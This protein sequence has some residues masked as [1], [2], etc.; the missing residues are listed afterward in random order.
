MKQ[1][2]FRMIYDFNNHENF[3]RTYDKLINSIYIRHLTKRL[4]IYIEHCSKC[5]LHQIKR[6]F[7]YDNLQS[8]DTS[9]IFFHT[10]TINFILILFIIDDMNCAFTITCKCNKKQ[11]IVFDKNI[12]DAKN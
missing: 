2:I 3:H 1:K 7:F 12:Y 4:R 10:L 9:M 8:I 11:L 6:H 5:Q